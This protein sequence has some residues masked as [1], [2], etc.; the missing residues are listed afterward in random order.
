VFIT[1]STKPLTPPAT[2][3][4][5]NT[6]RTQKVPPDVFVSKVEKGKILWT[7]RMGG[8]KEDVGRGVGV[9][10]AGNV[11]ASGWTDSNVWSENGNLAL[12]H[13]GGRDAFVAEISASGK[14]TKV[15]CVG[16]DAVEMAY[17]L[18]VDSKGNSYI[19]GRTN[20]KGWFSRGFDA[21]Q[22]GPWD[23]MAA[24][25]SPDGAVVWS[26]CLGG[27]RLDMA[28]AVAIDA[29]GNVYVGGVTDSSEDWLHG[30]PDLEYAG[31]RDA[32]VVKI[33]ADGSKMLWGSYV[34]GK[35]QEYAYGVG[36]DN[37]GGVYIGGMAQD[38]EWVKGGFDST[39]NGGGFDAIVA[40]IRE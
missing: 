2:F 12:K 29:K 24:K 31:G 37:H 21:E 34:G 19:A 33:A 39:Y 3:D 35:K 38:S 6:G 27:Q 11:Y 18:A 4:A 5:P 26:T 36:T 22:D 9:D 13:Y 14:L 20:S 15:T 40:R 30:G 23:A 7:T 28:R 1:G 17:G 8:D 16:G 25:V 32:F 10:S